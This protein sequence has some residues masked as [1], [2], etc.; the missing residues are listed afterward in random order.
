MEKAME[1]A[2]YK[3]KVELG[4]WPYYTIKIIYSGDNRWWINIS[5]LSNNNLQI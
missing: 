1:M 2:G 5:L 4:D 3:T